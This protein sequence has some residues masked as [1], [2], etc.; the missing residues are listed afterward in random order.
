[1]QILILGDI[2]SSGVYYLPEPLMREQF[3]CEEYV[4]K[5]AVKIVIKP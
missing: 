1:M 2:F 5:S 3:L 4:A